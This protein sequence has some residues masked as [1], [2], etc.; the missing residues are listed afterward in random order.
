MKNTAAIVTRFPRTC[1]W[2]I[3]N[4]CNLRCL[5]CELDAGERDESELTMPRML[6]LAG[7][8]KRAGCQNVSLTG[9]EP[10]LRRG[11]PELARRLADLGIRVKIVTNGILVDQQ[12]VDRMAE[13]GVMGVSVS[14]DGLREAHDALRVPAASMGSRFDAAVGAI[15][16]LRRSPLRTAVITQ[17]HRRNIEDLDA[18]YELLVSLGVDAWQVQ[19][20]FPLGRLLRSSM[21]LLIDPSRLPWLHGKLAA[22]ARDG[23]VPVVV[24]D[25]IG[26]Y[27]REEPILRKGTGGM[28]SFWMGCMAG[29]LAVS[30]CSNGDV[31]GCP[32]HPRPFVVGNV[33]KEPFEVIWADAGRFAYNTQWREELL[34]GRCASCPFRRVCR[35][36]CTTMAWAVTGT[37]YDNPFC[38]QRASPP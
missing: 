22:L 18:M 34:E 24:A 6:E 30:I 37:I 33:L 11:W 21:D 4:A 8:L 12:T 29:C 31:K 26:Y 1:V 38:V 3:T 2:D 15:E 20:A 25:N 7:E 14:L 19:L 32:S 23:R 16:I 10:L 13:A 27:A 9:G 36:G 5:H 17:I 28:S 35:A